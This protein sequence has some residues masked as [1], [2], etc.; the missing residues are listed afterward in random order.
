[1]LT[2]RQA[3]YSNLAIINFSMMSHRKILT[4][5]TW[6]NV[7]SYVKWLLLRNSKKIEVTLSN[8]L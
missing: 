7:D 5:S 4:P 8:D 1:M 6:L 2:T 3:S